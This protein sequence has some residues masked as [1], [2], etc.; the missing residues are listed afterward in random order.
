M[1]RLEVRYELGDAEL[2][3]PGKG[4]KKKPLVIKL[5]IEQGVALREAL[6]FTGMWLGTGYTHYE[7][8]A[9]VPKRKK[10]AAAK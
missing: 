10:R 7:W 6:S 3:I 2:T 1:D 5:S 8:P 9:D 4:P